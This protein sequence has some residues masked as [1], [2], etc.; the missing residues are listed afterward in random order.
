ML[1]YPFGLKDNFMTY[2]ASEEGNL[3][4][5]QSYGNRLDIENTSDKIVQCNLAYL[6]QEM[7]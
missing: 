6:L 1:E 4:L 3:Q 2:F 7:V 5:I